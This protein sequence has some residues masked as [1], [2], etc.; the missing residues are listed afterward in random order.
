[1]PVTGLYVVQE[2]GTIA[3]TISS[4]NDK[5]TRQ[6]PKVLGKWSIEY[7]L[8]REN[9]EISTPG[10]QG[11]QAHIDQYQQQPQSK[12]RF[13]SQLHLS[14][15]DDDVFN[16]IDEPMSYSAARAGI[17]SDKKVLAVFDKGM[18][19]IIGAKLQSMWL[20]RQSMR[21]EG[22]V[23]AIGDSFL[24]RTANVTQN[25]TFKFLIIEVEYLASDDLDAS[26]EIIAGFI[27]KCGFPQGRLF[28]GDSLDIYREPAEDP[29]KFGKIA[30]CLQYMEFFR[31][32][33]SG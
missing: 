21:A 30:H 7:K 18:D 11:S 26:K 31:M 23:F 9:P 27:T 19:S 8:F 24:V 12:A 22:H 29:K 6:F 20:L 14:T 3:S 15:H 32:R 13:L 2:P 33:P 25:G 4:I 17:K 10:R 16:L 5:I 1:M 28:F